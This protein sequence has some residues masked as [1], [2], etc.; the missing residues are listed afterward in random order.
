MLVLKQEILVTVIIP[1]ANFTT[2]HNHNNGM[3]VPSFILSN[4][5]LLSPRIDGIRLVVNKIAP[6]IAVFTQTRQAI[7]DSVVNIPGY[8]KSR[9][10]RV[11]RTHGGV[12]ARVYTFKIKYILLTFNSVE[13]NQSML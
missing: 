6:E 12:C 7:P 9:K 4:V 2:T 11:V 1:H 8:S 10:D 5:M 13:Y 3:F